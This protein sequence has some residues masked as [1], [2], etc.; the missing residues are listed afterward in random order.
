MKKKLIIAIIIILLLIVVGYLFFKDGEEEQELI[1]VK[2]G[3]ITREIFESGVLKMGEEIALG[4]RSGGEIEKIYVEKGQKVEKGETLALLEREDL[5]IEKRRA[6]Q[7][8]R[9]AQADLKILKETGREQDI[10]I[11][12]NKLE[13][14]ETSLELAKEALE[15]SKS[16]AQAAL[17]D[18]YA[19]AFSLINKSYITAKGI[20]DDLKEIRDEYFV[21]FYFSETYKARNS[22][23]VV[24]RNYDLLKEL[25]DEF[26]EKE[27]LPEAEKAYEIIER[28]VENIIDVADSTFYKNRFTSEDKEILW[29]AKTD[30][31]EML[32][33]ITSLINSI[34]SV[35]KQNESNINTAKSQEETARANYISARDSLERLKSGVRDLE[36]ESAEAN[37]ESLKETINLID[38]QIRRSVIIAPEKGK[39]ADI[40]AKEKEIIRAGEPLFSFISEGVAKIEV[41][42]YEGEVGFLNVEDIAL[43][44]LAAFAGEI[45][46][47]VITSINIADKVIDGVVYYE[48]IILLK[49]VPERARHGMTADI[50]IETVQK[51]DTLIISELA[52]E[53]KEGKNWV[54]VSKDNQLVPREIKTG[55]RGDRR[56]IEVIFGLEEGELI[57]L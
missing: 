54:M 19:P 56:Q 7:N 37:V 50:T 44:E 33:E 8:L 18:A 55:A 30:A 52:V 51:E 45:F 41:D 21:R 13:S 31:N 12:Q 39:I 27:S 38:Q 53:R 34:D 42:I 26:D 11:A 29:D 35:K 20:Y 9:S 1:E 15:Q 17:R 46:E 47:G 40:H 2:R 57:K 48:T 28:E 36:V 5:S 16:T 24:K 32:S 10:Q 3:D 25:V 43:V 23:N 6:E 22:I 49:D 14:V 4:T